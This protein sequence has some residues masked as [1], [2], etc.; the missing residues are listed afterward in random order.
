MAGAIETMGTDL[1]FRQAY[2]FYQRLQGIEL[3]RREAETFSNQ[4]HHLL[5]F[6]R[7][8]F[9]IFAE[10]LVLVAFQLLDDAS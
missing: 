1:A 10:V 8:G 9:R 2:G 7:I 3:Q 5:V 6:G 4:F